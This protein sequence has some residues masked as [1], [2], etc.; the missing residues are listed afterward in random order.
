MG[1]ENSTA[2]YLFFHNWSVVAACSDASVIAG[3]KGR[4]VLNAWMFLG[5]VVNPS[6]KTLK[7]W[8]GSAV[9]ASTAYN[10]VINT[11]ATLLNTFVARWN[12][13]PGSGTSPC[14][15]VREFHVWRGALSDQQMIY[16]LKQMEAK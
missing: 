10:P 11:N 5:V 14:L 4:G 8:N 7:T 9:M 2:T 12:L 13:E 6:T 15:D 16:E 1:T 3:G